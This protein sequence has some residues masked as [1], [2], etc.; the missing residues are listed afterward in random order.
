VNRRIRRGAVVGGVFACLV[1]GVVSIQIA[2]DLAAA[3]APP[4]A[5]PISMETLKSQLAAEQA[6]ATSLQQQLEDLLAVTTQLTTALDSTAAQVS[7]DGLTADQLRARLK[8][9]E[10]KLAS[11]NQLL[12]KAQAR[13]AALGQSIVDASG[14]TPPPAADA[15]GGG[16]G[17]T[18]ATPRP[19]ATAPPTSPFTLSLSLAGGGVKATWTKCSVSGFYA[20]A[21]VR[22]TDSEIHYPPEDRDTLVAEVSAVATTTATDGA[23]PTGS[24]WYRVYCLTRS[25]GETRVNKTT[26]TVKITAP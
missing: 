20:Y 4:P 8:A 5:P 18:G 11:V 22:S 1:F 23:A 21:V 6:R 10:A 2:A 3:A 12:K 26:S 14:R 25:G 16:G 24:L 15:G 19:A 17:T 13:L 7:D 9:A